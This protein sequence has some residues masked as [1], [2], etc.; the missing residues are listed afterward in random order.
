M[1]GGIDLRGGIHGDRAGR[2][3]GRGA[4]SGRDRT[5]IEGVLLR[6]PR[7]RHGQGAGDARSVPVGRGA[8]GQPGPLAARAEER[9]GGADAAGKEEAADRGAEAAV[10]YPAARERLAW[11]PQALLNLPRIASVERSRT[12]ASKILPF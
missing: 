1:V 10:G 9:P 8:P 7:R 6:L 11:T 3:S 4:V 5:G 12:L 2:A